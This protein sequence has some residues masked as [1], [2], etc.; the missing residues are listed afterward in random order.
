MR[1]GPEIYMEV[2]LSL[3]TNTKLHIYVMRLDR[4]HLLGKEQLP[5]NKTTPKQPSATA[6]TRLRGV[7]VSPTQDKDLGFQERPQNAILQE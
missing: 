2:L 7:L 3:W 4:D 6:H 1:K 5:G